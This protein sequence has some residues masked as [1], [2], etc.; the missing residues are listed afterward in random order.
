MPLQSSAAQLIAVF[1][2]CIFYGIYLVTFGAAL[3][4]ILWSGPQRSWALRL[5]SSRTMFTVVLLMFIFS[6]INLALGLVRILQ[7]FV[8]N[9][10]FGAN[11]TEQL[12]QD[13]VNIVK[14]R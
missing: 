10:R 4:C 9:A 2:E 11:A 14:V 8:Y 7:G 1:V 6:T 5:K 13:W 12:G 3:R